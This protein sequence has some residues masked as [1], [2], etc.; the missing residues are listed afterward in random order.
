MEIF[1]NGSKSP[2]N[3]NVNLLFFF[4]EFQG[5]KFEYFCFYLN[6]VWCRLC[7]IVSESA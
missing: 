3:E 5:K 1:N 7:E 6:K 2:L 4:V